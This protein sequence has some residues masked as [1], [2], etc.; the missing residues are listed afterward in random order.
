MLFRKEVPKELPGVRQTNG[1]FLT[2]KGVVESEEEIV[3]GS[4]ATAR[5]KKIMV[6]EGDMVRRGEPLVMLDKSKLMARVNMAEASRGE[7]KARLREL[8]NGYRAEDIE[9]AKS[10]FSR[11][12]AVHVKARDEYERKKKTL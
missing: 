11:A 10:R 3:I 12:E 5:V 9:M 1:A 4:L 7:A 8:E 6:D 2:A